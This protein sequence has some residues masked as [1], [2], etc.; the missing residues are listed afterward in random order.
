[1][2]CSAL[3][4]EIAVVGAPIMGRPGFELELIVKSKIH[5]KSKVEW[6]KEEEESDGA[7]HDV[8]NGRI[9]AVGGGM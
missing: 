9:D 6:K 4:I 7:C 3:F 1:M 5:R 2:D 8:Y